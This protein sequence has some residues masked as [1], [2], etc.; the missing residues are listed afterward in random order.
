MAKLHSREIL[1]YEI[2]CRPSCSERLVDPCEVTLGDHIHWR[3]GS[4]LEG[5]I[6][7]DGIVTCVST[8]QQPSDITVI[9]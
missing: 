6:W 4:W 2:S 3:N 5:R 9:R 7:R 1:D 8:E